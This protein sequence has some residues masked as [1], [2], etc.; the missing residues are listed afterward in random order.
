MDRLVEALIEEETLQSDRFHELAGL[1]AP[2]RSS[3][4]D[5]LPTGA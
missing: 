1:D 4:L 3:S 5:Q 2:S